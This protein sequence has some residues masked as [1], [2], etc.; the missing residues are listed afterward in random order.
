M[1]GGSQRSRAGA[2]AMLNKRRL[3]NA[4]AKTARKATRGKNGTETARFRLE[5]GARTGMI[6]GR[7]NLD[8]HGGLWKSS[9]KE[10][11]KME[12]F[13]SEIVA[14]ILAIGIN[15]Y[16]FTLSKI[17]LGLPAC[18]IGSFGCWL[19]L[20]G[21]LIN[22]K[23]AIRAGRGLQKCGLALALL[24]AFGFGC[25]IY[26][27]RAKWQRKASDAPPPPSSMFNPGAYSNS[28]LLL[29]SNHRVTSFTGFYFDGNLLNK[30]MDKNGAKRRTG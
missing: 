2:S 19:V 6:G 4:T 15:C 22:E 21:L 8:R 7:C 20:L 25:Q 3:A 13:H 18:F 17:L 26:S 12:N 11:N 1:A 27:T 9:K 28:S 24:G 10:N 30:A 23:K 16:Y 14:S 29:L 5:A